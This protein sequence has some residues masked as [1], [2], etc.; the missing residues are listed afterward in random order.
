M[1][2]YQRFLNSIAQDDLLRSSK[3]FFDFLTTTQ[4]SEFQLKMKAYQTILTP[5]TLSELQSRSG[6]IDLQTEV[7]ES[8]ELWNKT[9][10]NIQSNMNLLKK[11]NQSFTLLLNEI[12]QV[13]IRFTELSTIY[14]EMSTLAVNYQNKS[15]DDSLYKN[16]L[17]M[18]NLMLDL[19]YFYKKQGMLFDLDLKQHIKY[20]IKEYSSFKEL[21]DNFNNSKVN[22]NKKK[23]KLLSKKEDFFKKKDLKK[24]DLKAEDTQI[25]VNNKELAFE[26][27]LPTETFELLELKK[28]CCFLGSTYEIEFERVG[29]Y[30]EIQN[31]AVLQEVIDKNKIVVKELSDSW[32]TPYSQLISSPITTNTTTAEN[33]NKL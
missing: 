4:E 23:E 14:G 32:N 28:F 16:Y 11:L 10:D 31:I 24:W 1:K 8:N 9:T 2:N 17:G 12:K 7:L 13:S 30:I 6:I 5:K 22:Y 26:K 33:Q 20:V 21:R 3:L 27:M 29:K 19:E 15:N 25:D 18:K